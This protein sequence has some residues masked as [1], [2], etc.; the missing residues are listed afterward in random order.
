M[1]TIKTRTGAMADL[2]MNAAALYREDI[3]T[4]RDLGT[5][6]QM[7]PVTADGTPD[8]SRPTLYAGQT[9][10]LTPMGT[11]PISFEI[12][13][14]SLKEAAEK[15]GASAKEAI[16]RTMKEIQELRREAASQIV[17]PEAAPGRFGG[18]GTGGAPGG[19]RIK[20]P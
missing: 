5:I 7:T 9:Q 16:D 13:A 11:L 2:D 8:S 15:F 4:D 6:R 18:P 14:R 10:L 20:L 12:P 19:G 17:I 3:Y 1:S